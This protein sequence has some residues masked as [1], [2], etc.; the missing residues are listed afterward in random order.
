[1][2]GIIRVPVHP[3][4]LSPGKTRSRLHFPKRTSRRKRPD[5]TAT[6]R[7]ARRKDVV[8]EQPGTGDTANARTIFL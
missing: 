1:M 4:A 2:M 7:P 6:K 8:Y 5:G 3:P